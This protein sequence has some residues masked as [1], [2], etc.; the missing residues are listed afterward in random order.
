MPIHNFTE[1]T[2]IN[3]KVFFEGE[4]EVSDVDLKAIKDAEK[5]SSESADGEES[6][7]DKAAAKKGK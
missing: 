3:N 7:T 5:I 2:T 6:Q 1:T 4:A